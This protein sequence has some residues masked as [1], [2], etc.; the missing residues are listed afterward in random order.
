MRTLGRIVLA[1]LVLAVL[2]AVAFFVRPIWVT[3]Q[4]THFGL[5][6]SHVQSNYVLTPEGRVHYYEAEP[7]IPGGGT[8]IVLVHGLGD[9]DEAWAPMLKRL[10]RAG[11]H[12]YAPD[13]LGYG[14]SPKPQ[15]GDYSVNGE[16]KFVYDFIQAL[17]LQK[18]DV[19]GWSMGGWIALKLALDH[20][21]VVDRV[22]VYDPAG[23]RFN[24]SEPRKLFEP[25]TT[26]DVQRLF[27]VMEPDAKPIPNYVRRDLLRAI[28]NMQWT[29]D[30]N[31]SSMTEN[32]LLTNRVS[33]LSEPLLI[34][35]GADD[36]LIP[37]SVGQQMH[38]LVPSSELDILAGCGHLAPN[39]CSARAAQAT[40]DFLKANPVP[41]GS[42]RTLQ[43]MH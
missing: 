12:V 3:R 32:D 31:L 33:S 28:Q 41:T 19:G 39:R 18:T 11:F 25:Q 15:D 23:L 6:L 7:R 42:V 1:V 30:K 5:F 43:S 38:Q 14:R 22:V 21:D 17:G 2:L 16:T 40:A 35:W 9:R 34:V 29:V 10:K 20:P 36:K 4:A 24:I 37:L 27:S 26:D 8:P 13:L